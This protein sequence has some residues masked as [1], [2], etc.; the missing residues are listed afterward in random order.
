MVNQVVSRH[1]ADLEPRKILVVEDERIIA[2]DICKTL[3]DMGY[4]V[5]GSARSSTE[6]LEQAAA[7]RPHLVLMDVR[8]DGELDGIEL[9]T[10]LKRLYQVPV[11]FLTG[12]TDEV[13]LQRAFRA[14]PDGYLSKPFSRATLRTAMEVA[15]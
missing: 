8:I 5:C 2:R 10:E 14:E 15:F 11:V 7:E 6:A 12:N 13:T 1:Q 4:T 3:E 9:S